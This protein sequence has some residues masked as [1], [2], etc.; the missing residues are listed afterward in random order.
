MTKAE[1]LIASRKDLDERESSIGDVALFCVLGKRR[2]VRK[3]FTTNVGTVRTRFP[4]GQECYR[5]D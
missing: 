5:Q 4:R 3:P 2:L 1:D